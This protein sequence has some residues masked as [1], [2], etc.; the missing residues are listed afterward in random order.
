MECRIRNKKGLYKWHLSRALPVRDEEDNIIMWVGSN[1]EIHNQKEQKEELESAFRYR[2]RQLQRKNM[3]L[4][5]ANKDLTTLTYVSSH[6]LQEPLRKIQNFVK[7]IYKN[8]NVNL[9]EAGKGYLERLQISTKRMHSLIEDLLTYSRTGSQE[10][11]F[12][13]TN[14]RNIINEVLSDL[15]DVIQKKNAQIDIGEL[16]EVNIIPF[17]FRQLFQNLIGNALKFSKHKRVPHIKISCRVKTGAE[18]ENTKL[19]PHLNYCH[20]TLSD[21]GIGFDPQYKERIFE[22]FQR[23]HSFENY[24][25]T[26]IGLAI[27]KRIV[28]NHAGIITASGELNEGATFDIYIPAD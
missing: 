15:E 20:V 16:C 18:L 12:E 13:K 19:A 17:Q 5:S 21:N 23:L 10:K 26:G 28:E 11:T 25:G 6:D 8:D 2:T 24:K 27:C 3:E 9:S 4:E 14:L 1:T 7:L 22:V